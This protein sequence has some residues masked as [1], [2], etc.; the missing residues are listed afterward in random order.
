ML[1]LPMNVKVPEHHN[2]T[3]TSHYVHEQFEEGGG[4]TRPTRASI[5]FPPCASPVALHLTMNVGRQGC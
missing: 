1:P 2:E 5:T 4:A 3:L